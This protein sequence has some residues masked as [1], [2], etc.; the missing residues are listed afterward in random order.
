MKTVINKS[1][2]FTYTADLRSL[3]T[4][5]GSYH[6]SIQSA[7]GGAKD[8]EG[9]RTLFQITADAAGMGALRDLIDGVIE[10]RL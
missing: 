6:L 3:A 8:P 1:G 5:A 10:R 2:E 4:P 9:Q 7:H